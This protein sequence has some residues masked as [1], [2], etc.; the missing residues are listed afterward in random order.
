MAAG[1]LIVGLS[2][3]SFSDSFGTSLM[4]VGGSSSKSVEKRTRVGGTSQGFLGCFLSFIHSATAANSERSCALS[5]SNLKRDLNQISAAASTR[6]S[7][8][9]T[10]SEVPKSDL[11]GL[12]FRALLSVRESMQIHIGASPYDESPATL[13]EPDYS[14]RVRAELRA[15]ANQCR[16]IYKAQHGKEMTARLSLKRFNHDFGEYFELVAFAENA[17]EINEV[18]WLEANVPALWDEEALNELGLVRDPDTLELHP[19]NGSKP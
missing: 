15:F 9:V 10:L 14:V 16:R 4:R 19:C 12:N 6:F 18:D 8:G 13:D 11:L 3:G 17:A 1:A 2:A 5:L 7:K